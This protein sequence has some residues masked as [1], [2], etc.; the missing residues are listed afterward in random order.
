[1]QLIILKIC[2]DCGESITENHNY[3]GKIKNAN[4]HSLECDCGA[5]NGTQGHIWTASGVGKVKCTLCGFIKILTPGEDIPI[6]KN[7]EDIEEETE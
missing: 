3:E 2:T 5:T 1:M 7:K 6:I 4:V